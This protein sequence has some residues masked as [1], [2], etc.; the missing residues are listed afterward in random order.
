M[1]HTLAVDIGTTSAKAL[2]VNE[3]G[4]VL[5]TAQEYYPTQNPEPDYAEQNPDEIFSAVKKIIRLATDAVEGKVD[6]VSFSSAMH[7][8]ILV[9]KVGS[10][11]SPMITWADLRSKHEAYNLRHSEAGEIIYK[12]TGTPIHPMSPLCKMLWLKKYQTDW[13]NKAHKFIGIREYIGYKL[14]GEFTVDHSI[15]SATG[16]FN[17]GKLA[18]CEKALEVTGISGDRLST[19]QSV[20]T[21]S[22]PDK[23]IASMLGI[24]PEVPWI[25]GANDGCLANLGSDAMDGDTLSVTV[26]TSG[27][28]RKAVKKI[29]PDAE[30]RTFHYLLDEEN[31]ITGGAT[32][33]GAVLVQWFAE[34]ILKEK[35]NVHSFGER[36]SSVPAGAEGLIFLPYVLGE[37]APVYDAE[38]TGVFFGVRR[39]HTTEHFMRAVLEGVCFALYSI[40]EIVEESTGLA[41][42]MMASGGF[43]KSPHWVQ[44]MASM[45][46]KE[47]HVRGTAD[48]SSLGAA[49]LGFKALGVKT[50]FQFPTEK[51][52]YPDRADH[53]IYQDYFSVYKRLYPHLSS[54]FKALDKITDL[55][56]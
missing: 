37:R 8:L 51:I 31:I 25:L 46:D 21:I 35:I 42:K 23:A 7:S 39:H 48:A 44:M 16:L 38:S 18:W 6:S 36:A 56:P 54:D 24:A 47:V 43:I 26:G 52:Y 34:S 45:F 11:I 28:V 32:N 1:K 2:V 29:M 17:G 30:G 50:N 10:A 13:F 55:I 9:D 19:P 27:A 4:E 20:Y 53:S 40:S 49:L 33:N 3:S 22:R 5:S 14:F 12:E 15:A 41:K